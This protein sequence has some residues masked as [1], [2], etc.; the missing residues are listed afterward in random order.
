[1]MVWCVMVFEP[2]KVGDG[3]VYRFEDED[4]G[5]QAE[6][7]LEGGVVREESWEQQYPSSI[8]ASPLQALNVRF[9]GEEPYTI[10]FR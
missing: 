5:E 8:L 9:R 4:L 10:M 1:M 7:F 6:A 3:E 2:L